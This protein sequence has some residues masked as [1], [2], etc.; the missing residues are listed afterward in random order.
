MVKVTVG[1]VV[2]VLVS[3]L[4]A[5][6]RKGLFCLTILGCNSFR[7]G[8]SSWPKHEAAGR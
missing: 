8:L 3:F 6:T 7:V 1:W 2:D 4:T 5:L